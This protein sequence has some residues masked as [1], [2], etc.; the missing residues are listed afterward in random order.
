MSF[1]L[2]LAFQPMSG[3]AVNTCPDRIMELK[4][5]NQRSASFTGEDRRLGYQLPV[6]TGRVQ[7]LADM[8][9]FIV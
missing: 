4:Q 3:R 7:L 6:G 5:T 9:R 2:W 8:E 1:D